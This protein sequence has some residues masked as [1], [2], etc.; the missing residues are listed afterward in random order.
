MAPYG[1]ASL[2]Y[3]NMCDPGKVVWGQFSLGFQFAVE[4]TDL[5]CGKSLVL[6]A[7][8]FIFVVF[9]KCF[10]CADFNTDFVRGQLLVHQTVPEHLLSREKN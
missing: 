6:C 9:G 1:V 3:E 10:S 8:T 5:L 4:Q 2:F 7:V